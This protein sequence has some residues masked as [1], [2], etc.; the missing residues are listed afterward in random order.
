MDDLLNKH[1]P[2]PWRIVEPAKWPWHIGIVDAA[3]DLVLRMEMPSHSTSDKTLADVLAG[4]C[5]ADEA[6]RQRAIEANAAQMEKARRIVAEHNACAGIETDKLEAMRGT[7]IL[8]TANEHFAKTLKQR[9]ELLHLLLKAL[10]FVE[11]H[12]GSPVYKAG[13]V[14]ATVREIRAAIA[15]VEGDK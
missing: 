8:V 12:E 5:W 15:S 13:Y 1:H 3:G 11:D 10:P 2:A 14:A 7:T 4:E 6:A 9:D